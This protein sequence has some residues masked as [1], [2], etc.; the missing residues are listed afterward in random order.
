MTQ[1]KK[2]RRPRAY[3][4]GSGAKRKDGGVKEYVA[5]PFSA[6]LLAIWQAMG[7]GRKIVRYALMK[8]AEE[9]G[10]E[11]ACTHQRFYLDAHDVER[12]AICQKAR[13]Q[14]ETYEEFFDPQKPDFI[15]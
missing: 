12:C 7:G 1:E 9:R 6:P 13:K 14:I 10:I 3:S 4:P 8:L 15:D 2:T 11:G 5:I